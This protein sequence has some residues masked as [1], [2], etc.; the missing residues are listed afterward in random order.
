MELNF[1]EIEEKILKFWQKNKIFEK[2]QRKNQGKKRWSFID[3]PITANNP[4]GIHHAWA[5]TYKDLFQRYKAMQGFNQRFQNGFDCHGLW[6]EV[7][8]EKELGFKGKKDIEKFGIEKFV[9]ICKE[10]ARKYSKIQTEQSK[11]LGQWMDWENSYYTLTDTNIE[12]IWHFLKKCHQKG[13][14]YKAS[15]VLPW[16]KRCGTSLSQHEVAEGYRELTHKA[17]YFKLK[18]KDSKFKNGYFLVWTTTPW[19]LSSNVALAVHPDLD[20][21]QVAIE[22][23]L[24]ILAKARLGVLGGLKYRIQEKFK[25][26]KLIALRY[27]GPFDELPVQKGVER[28]VI[29]SK[30]V[31]ET[32]GTGIVHIAPGCGEE[33]YLLGK[34]YNLKVIAP[35]DEQGFFLKY[36]GWLSGKN[37]SEVNQSIFE[38]LKKKRILFK[39]EDYHHRYPC[40]WR[41][42][43]ELVFR[44]VD[45]WFIGV[46]E[47]R[48]LMKR[49]AKKVNWVPASDGKRMQ[50]WL[51]NMK[52]WNISRK[53]YW[54]LP[55]MFFECPN[56]HLEVIG[57]KKELKKKAINPKLVDKLPELHR[58]WID[59]VKIKCSR[60][61]KPVQRIPEVGDCWLDAGIVPFSTLKYLEDKSYWQKWFPAQLIS[62]MRAQISTWYYSLL[63]MA[64]TL[65]ERAPYKNVFSCGEVR[66]EKGKGMHKS[67]G[68]V[69]W[70]DE[71]INKI[72]ADVM[73]WM[74]LTQNPAFNLNFGY[75]LGEEIT[76]KLMILWNTYLFFET[77]A[78]KKQRAEPK[79]QSNHILDRWITSRLNELVQQVTENLDKYDVTS[80]ARAIEDFII[81][82]FSQW[83]IRRSRKRF[84]RPETKRELKEASGTLNYVLLTLSKLIAPF[85]PF[86]SEEIYKNLT[87]KESVH[88]ENWPKVNKKLINKKLNQEMEKTRKIVA[89][90]LTERAKAKIRVR[91]PLRTLWIGEKLEKDFL[92]LI[93]KEINVK[94]MEYK[95]GLKDKVKLDTKITPE[96]K[97]EGSLREIIRNIQEMRKKIGLKPK[98]KILVGYFGTPELNKILVRNKKF[99]LKEAKVK[100]LIL[101]E[102][103]KEVFAA[104]RKIEVDGQKLWI[105]I[106]KI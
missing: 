13:W 37:V 80:A 98:N 53:R 30:E 64:V 16:C 41:C 103:P 99:I 75:K 94:K 32:E 51:D 62:E 9:K 23:E 22:K 68:N 56:G 102:K 46:D 83:Y 27:Q 91:Q 93:E 81:E 28:K 10:R 58:P 84:Q 74:Y 19:T 59:Q 82:D 50:D 17:I 65:E 61:K 36:F 89:L 7:E 54:G 6:V 43:E 78:E 5:R 96:L 45:E 106:K 26:K 55:L 18:I 63:F 14:L 31:S 57:S 72:G 33:D 87:K 86:I 92:D 4:M 49:E 34:E 3:G 70:F 60:C 77:Y 11:R 44:L 24:L 101:G 47:I 38:D 100:D 69:I 97:E 40:C 105:T 48:S 8:V 85:A 76:R 73:R 1:P 66:D 39:T 15:R 42:R 104:E 88:L 52:D 79:V 29:P 95:E 2:L 67:L 25:G 35:L 20:Y 12:Y 90:A 21:V 71:A